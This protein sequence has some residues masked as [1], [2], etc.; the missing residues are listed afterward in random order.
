[1]RTNHSTLR[2]LHRELYR[3]LIKEATKKQRKYS[4]KIYSL[5]QENFVR[6][7]ST[8]EYFSAR[9]RRVLVAYFD[10]NRSLNEARFMQIGSRVLLSESV[11]GKMN[12]GLKSW[13]GG[14]WNKITKAFGNL[15][16]MITE[17]VI[18]IKN[19]L[20]EQ[21]KK[22]YDKGVAT[23][24]SSAGELTKIFSD[25]LKGGTNEEDEKGGK[26]EI[27]KA[28]GKVQLV[29]EGK[30]LA[31]IADWANDPV[32]KFIAAFKKKMPA[33]ATA[34]KAEAEVEA[35]AESGGE[36]TESGEKSATE[37]KE[38]WKRTLAEIN[39]APV[40]DEKFT[41]ILIEEEESL[42]TDVTSKEAVSKWQKAGKVAIKV[43]KI[44]LTVIAGILSPLG[45]AVSVAMKA[46]SKYVVNLAAKGV[47]ALGGPVA[48]KYLVIPAII[49]LVAKFQEDIHV[50][51]DAVNEM[52]GALLGAIPIVGN[53]LEVGMKIVS[54]IFMALSATYV[55]H[56][57]L[58]SAEDVKD[59]KKPAQSAADLLRE[60]DIVKENYL[61]NTKRYPG[62]VYALK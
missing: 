39:G 34:E 61:K 49:A 24:K 56:Y 59:L 50:L 13:L 40:F 2:S 30:H 7:I 62:R 48:I 37:L 15:K 44:V 22:I 52:A 12:E 10:K 28:G 14:V 23:L 20:I 29:K 55:I 26:E 27:E 41:R 38:V 53:S 32:E 21:G 45:L 35:A 57:A 16:K 31:T 47:E 42:P 17:I 33:D 11:D 18:K 60:K 54:G 51:Y 6:H 36:D 9:E 4:P 8:N 43:L 1:M 3:S 25:V 19:F 5:F 58:M 46:A